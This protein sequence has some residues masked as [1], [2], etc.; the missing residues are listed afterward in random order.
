MDKIPQSNRKPD[1]KSNV[2]ID[3]LTN[4]SSI[5]DLGHKWKISPILIDIWRNEFIDKANQLLTEHKRIV[6]DAYTSWVKT[7]KNNFDPL[8]HARNCIEHIVIARIIDC[9]KITEFSWYDYNRFK[10]QG[11]FTKENNGK[12]N[13]KAYIDIIEHYNLLP[14]NVIDNIEEIRLKGNF[15][16]HD[17]PAYKSEIVD[18]HIKLTSI[19]ENFFLIYKEPLWKE[20]YITTPVDSM[21]YDYAHD[22]AKQIKK[23]EKIEIEEKIKEKQNEER[24]I[25]NFIKRLGISESSRYA[26]IDELYVPPKE[27]EEIKIELEKER[28]V[29][30]SGLP[31]FGKTFTAVKLLWEWYKNGYHP[32]WEKGG[33]EM[34]RE[35]V[36]QNFGTSIENLIPGTIYYYEDPFGKNKYENQGGELETKIL[37]I[38]KDIRN[39]DNTYVI[40]T[41]REDIF[42]EFKKQ[43]L[44]KDI[45][46]QF[47]KRI[48]SISHFYN[49]LQKEQMLL[50]YGIF[51][52][53]KW[54]NNPE[55]K[56]FLFNKI[57]DDSILPTP[58]SIFNFSISSKNENTK[59]SLIS[60]LEI[61]SQEIGRRF[62]YEVKL[63][64]EKEKLFFTIL[65][66]NNLYSFCLILDN[67]ADKNYQ[68][69]SE[70][71]EIVNKFKNKKFDIIIKKGVGEVY[72]LIHP[73]YYKAWEYLKTDDEFIKIANKAIL[74][75]HHMGKYWIW[76]DQFSL[77]SNELIKMIFEF[78]NDPKEASKLAKYIIYYYERLPK[79]IQELVLKCLYTS[80][81]NITK[82]DEIYVM[83]PLMN[84]IIESW[85][86]LPNEVRQYVLKYGG[87]SC[88]EFLITN[89]N[90]ISLEE[91][92]LFFLLLDNG[93]ANE[94]TLKEILLNYN[95]LPDNVK[96][97]ILILIPQIGIYR[98][99]C[100]YNEIINKDTHIEFPINVEE[101]FLIHFLAAKKSDYRG[102][103][104]SIINLLPEKT[105][106]ILFQ[107]K[108]LNQA[109]PD[110]L[111][112][113]LI[114][115]M[116]NMGIKFYLELKKYL[117]PKQVEKFDK[118]IRK[119]KIQI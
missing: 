51:H 48:T 104:L 34:E 57:K 106:M 26:K 33:D 49:S 54:R 72:Y 29:F 3:Y 82:F 85:S 27:Y 15:S 92:N 12:F 94:K 20:K 75:S 41:T 24:T 118:K 96:K 97:T 1:F 119:M 22:I 90:S 84:A 18:F 7:D 64:N 65:F 110:F 32:K 117:D 40:I 21:F 70:F 87:D 91:Q 73:A 17:D 76:F 8:H 93:R 109:L 25:L 83:D 78:S 10:N 43:S 89:W 60:N 35:K 36:R 114:P 59:E 14:E 37:Q 4:Q 102:I 19:V 81:K 99:I 50:N 56:D 107:N 113:Y 111:S 80:E 115:A 46:N 28:I 95:F 31:E 77:L 53:C 6:V 16:I 63:M 105:K 79:E 68:F 55:L 23:I 58:L 9:L 39:T 100:L 66:F 74:S 69:S 71:H 42:E 98:L 47:E 44:S 52:N 30:I 86:V 13:L 2:V 45:L 88:C 61:E 103:I 112:F 108:I 38:I 67:F 101:F 116:G 5:D 62:A 11:V